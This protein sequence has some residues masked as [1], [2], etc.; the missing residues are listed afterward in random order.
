MARKGGAPPYNEVRI[1][2]DPADRAWQA[3]IVEFHSDQFKRVPK[4]LRRRSAAEEAAN[5][6]THG[7]GAVLG[8]TALILLVLAAVPVGPL[9][10]VAA[11]IFGATLVLVYLS[12]TLHHGLSH[13]SAKRLFLL[14]DRCAIYLLI[15]G[16][17]TPITILVLPPPLGL[18]LTA[19]I[20]ALAA[21]GIGLEA[22]GHRRERS[23]RNG[24]GR[25]AWLPIALYLGMGWL[26]LVVAGAALVRTLAP[27]AL[28]WLIAG[29][30]VYTIGVVFYLWR[31]LPYG[32]AVWHLFA[33]AGSA[34]HVWAILGYVLPEAA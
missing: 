34:C 31:R 28:D 21:L 1:S 13:A 20:W 19:A 22:L 10:V 24:L 14:C 18:T 5:A 12:S 27:A 16:T 25:L 32:H 23:G 29:G 33:V 30:A 6:L 9:A 26:G 7:V 3:T 2:A 15:A 11:A 4:P 17:Y 8:L